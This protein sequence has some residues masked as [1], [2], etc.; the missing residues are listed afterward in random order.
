MKNLPHP[1]HRHVTP[2]S[3][4]PVVATPD[5]VVP[6]DVVTQD[7]EEFEVQHVYSERNVKRNSL[8]MVKRRRGAGWGEAY[9]I[10]WRVY[11]RFGNKTLPVYPLKKRSKS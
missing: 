4:N 5:N 9:H 2:Y 8:F 1:I 7:G 3:T 6:G 10:N 11:T